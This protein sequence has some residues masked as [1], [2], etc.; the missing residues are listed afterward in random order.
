MERVV[1]TGVA[2]EDQEAIVGEAEIASPVFDHRGAPAGSIGV[3]GPVERL[4]PDGPA[5][6]LV[7]AVKETARGLSREMGAGRLAAR[8]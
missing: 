1:A 4:A 5:P 2:F 7:A 3:V 8:G 6:T